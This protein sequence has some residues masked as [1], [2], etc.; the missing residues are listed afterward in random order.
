MLT[1]S[2]SV[3]Q[4]KE[5]KMKFAIAWLV[6]DVNVIDASMF[7]MGEEPRRLIVTNT[8]EA[9]HIVAQAI[10]ESCPADFDSTACATYQ[11]IELSDE[12]YQRFVVAGASEFYELE[13]ELLAANVSLSEPDSGLVDIGSGVE[14]LWADGR[15]TEPPDATSLARLEGWI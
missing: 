7:C 6:C 1:V 11:V 9:A 2:Y 4:K 3:V 12:L 8:E 10:Q 14:E 5:L 13:A 15:Y